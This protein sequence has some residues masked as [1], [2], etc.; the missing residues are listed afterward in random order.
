MLYSLLGSTMCFS[1]VYLATLVNSKIA[2][3]VNHTITPTGCNV[4]ALASSLATN[5]IT[6]GL[7]FCLLMEMRTIRRGISRWGNWREGLSRFFAFIESESVYC[8]VQLLNLV[9]AARAGNELSSNILVS[10]LASSVI[11]LSTGM[12][13]AIRTL[14]A[15]LKNNTVVLDTLDGERLSVDCPPDTRTSRTDSVG[16]VIDVEAPVSL[17]FRDS[18]SVDPQTELERAIADTI[19]YDRG[20]NTSDGRT[21]DRRRCDDVINRHNIPPVMVHNSPYPMPSIP[22]SLPRLFDSVSTLHTIH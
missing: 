15:Q 20:T 19:Q 13:P 6:T 21:N 2:T 5:I 14:L 4:A 8:I 9:K 10:H 16:N 18:I 1:I 22:Y 3:V 17:N 7:S 11:D 12:Y